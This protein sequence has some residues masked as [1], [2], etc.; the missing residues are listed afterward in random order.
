LVGARLETQEIWN[1]P[2]VNLIWGQSEAI[3]FLE[4][5]LLRN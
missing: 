1:H 5:E 2:K 3:E 4:D